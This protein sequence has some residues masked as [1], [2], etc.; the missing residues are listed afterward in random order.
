MDSDGTGITL[1]QQRQPLLPELG[2]TRIRDPAE[3]LQPAGKHFLLRVEILAF[4]GFAGAWGGVHVIVE[5]HYRE[6]IGR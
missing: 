3:F 6:L 1:P 4:E 2:H 5:I